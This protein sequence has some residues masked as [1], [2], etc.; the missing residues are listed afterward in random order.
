MRHKYLQLMV[1]LSSGVVKFV[2]SKRVAKHY[3]QM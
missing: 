1:K 3:Q 2:C